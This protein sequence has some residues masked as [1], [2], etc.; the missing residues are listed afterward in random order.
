MNNSSYRISQKAIEDLESIW[1]YTFQN[2]SK[3]QAD[4]YYKLIIQEIEYLAK[5]PFS[6]KSLKPGLCIRICSESSNRNKIKHLANE[7]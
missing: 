6:G 3:E 1:V 5:D 2:W 4:R 7:A